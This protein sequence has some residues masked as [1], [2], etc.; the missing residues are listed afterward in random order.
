MNEKRSWTEN[1]KWNEFKYV[2]PYGF[3]PLAEEE[4]ERK[5]AEAWKAEETEQYTGKI[6]YRLETLSPLFIPDTSLKEDK[7]DK[8]KH[9]TYEFFS[10]GDGKPVIPGSE[11]RGM[12]RNLYETLTNS[13]VPFINQKEVFS[14]RTPEYFKPGILR[15]TST[16][17]ELITVYETADYL[18]RENDRE[19]FSVQSFL[20]DQ[21]PQDGSEVYFDKRFIKG[22]SKYAKPFAEN[23]SL[24]RENRRK[25]GYL[26][27]GQSGPELGK[28]EKASKCLECPLKTKVRCEQE[29]QKRC[30]FLE[31]HC[32]HI[33]TTD[34]RWDNIKEEK[35]APVSISISAELFCDLSER[36]ELLLKI[37]E[38]KA[39]DEEKEVPY[40]EYK[41]TWQRFLSGEQNAIPLYFSQ[42]SENII[43]VSPA[44]ITREVYRN[45]LIS[46]LENQGR[47]QCCDGTTLCPACALF[48]T[49]QKEYKR[50]SKLRF[51]DLL[52]EEKENYYEPFLTLSE[53][54]SPKVSTAEF[55]L[56]KPKDTEG[57]VLNWTY[58]YYVLMQSNGNLVEKT[59]TNTP[60][61]LAGRK[62]Y[63]HSPDSVKLL[64]SKII[65]KNKR[66]KTVHPVKNKVGF[67]GEVYFEGITKKQ[68]DELIAILNL[69]KEDSGN[70]RYAAK[71]GSA[72]PLGLG[73]VGLSVENVWIRNIGIDAE[74]GKFAYQEKQYEEVFLSQ[75]EFVSCDN[76]TVSKMF[77]KYCEYVLKFLDMGA[78]KGRVAYYP[79]ALN[80]EEREE[81]FRWF[82]ENRK[83][84][85][86]DKE[87]KLDLARTDDGPKSRKQTIYRKYM[88][89]AKPELVSNKY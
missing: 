58:E 74:T 25:I 9:H 5:T 3:V 45:T 39:R 48:G 24:Q 61:K 60:V 57:K 46:I 20:S 54:S 56:Q 85:K 19:D 89:T 41:R 13:C 36:M 18:Y 33:F 40:Q 80:K 16:E 49:V 47:H 87:G 10:Y 82:S 29:N 4:P 52:A 51:S 76:I 55:Y 66:N 86:M 44:K 21:L 30:Y 8:E 11:V 53:L 67:V 75:K 73:S 15:R 50:A 83:A 17:Y 71:L 84:V 64:R 69:S 2:N 78:L 79:Y 68:L 27:K 31:K 35:I 7:K 72:K 43:Y 14:K 32:A 63:W 38:I 88:G 6:V 59:Y 37:Y 65:E 12:V 23:I 22:R 62:F 28:N 1:R 81:G 42:I 77:E 70:K 34:S 26:L